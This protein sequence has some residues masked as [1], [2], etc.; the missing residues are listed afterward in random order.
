MNQWKFS[1]KSNEIL[2]SNEFCAQKL[3][4]FWIF[5]K[6]FDYRSN[7]DLKIWS[8]IVFWAEDLVKPC[9]WTIFTENFSLHNISIIFE[10]AKNVWTMENYLTAAKNYEKFCAAKN[11]RQKTVKI[12]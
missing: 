9:F 11:A 3:I 6:K 10:V 7:F 5:D 1:Q 2:P 8:A 12:V 4:S